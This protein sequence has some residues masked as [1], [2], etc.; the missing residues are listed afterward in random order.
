MEKSAP[1]EKILATPTLLTLFFLQNVYKT[2]N[3]STF[4]SIT[5]VSSLFALDMLTVVLDC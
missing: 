2:E 1:L 3:Q 5:I 4:L